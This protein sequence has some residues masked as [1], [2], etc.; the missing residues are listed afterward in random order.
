M[1][2]EAGITFLRTR[3]RLYRR[4]DRPTRFGYDVWDPDLP[5]WR[6]SKYA[7]RSIG[8]GGSASFWTIPADE[9]AETI[10]LVGGTPDDL[11]VGIDR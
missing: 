4:V 11:W 7:S 9:A 6:P 3:H 2:R 5:E 10:V 8:L 1:R